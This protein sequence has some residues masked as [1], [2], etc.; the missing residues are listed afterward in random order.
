[1]QLWLKRTLR[2]GN[3]IWHL[4]ISVIMVQN[5]VFVNS[6]LILLVE[7]IHLQS[8]DLNVFFISMCC[9]NLVHVNLYC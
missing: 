9:H 4:F 7:V 3:K 8:I 5:Y 2:N 6:F 1:M